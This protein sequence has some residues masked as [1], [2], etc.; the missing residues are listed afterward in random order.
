M[1]PCEEVAQQGQV[2]DQSHADDASPTVESPGYNDDS[3]SMEEDD[4]EDPEEDP[5]DEHNPRMTMRIPR[6]IPMRSMS[7]RMKILKR[8]SSLRGLMRSNHSRKTRLLS[9]HHHLDTMQRGYL[10]TYDQAPLGH[11]AAMIRMSDDIPEEDMPPR[12]RFVLTAPLPGCD[13]AESYAAAARAPRGH[14][15]FVDTVVAG[16]SLVCSPG[17]DALTIV[18]AADRA[19]DVGNATALQ[20]S[21]H[22][23][24]TSIEEVNLRI[25]Y[26]A[27]E[28]RHAYLSF[29]ARNKALLARLETLETHMS[30]MKWQRQSAE[31]LVVTQMMRIHAVEAQAWTDTVEDSDSVVGLSQWLKKMESVFHISSCA[32]D[33]QVKFATC[34]LLG[35]A[36]TWWNGR[37]RN[38]GHDAAYA[39]TWGNL[40]KKLTDKYCPKG[41]IKKLEIELWN[42]KYISGLPDNIHEHVMSARPKTLDDAIE[43]TS[44]LMDQ[45]LHTYVERQNDNKRNADDSSRNNQQPHKKQNVARAYTVSLG[46]K[47]AYTV[48]TTNN[49]NNKNQKAGACYECGDTEHIKKN[50][51]KLKNRENGVALG[52]AYAMGGRDASSDSNIITGTLLLNNRYATILFNT[53]ADRSFVSTTF[54]AL[55]DITPTTLE[56]HYDVE[57]ADRKIIRVNTIIRGCTLNFMNHPFNID[58]MPVPLGSFDVIIGMDWL[59]K[60]HGIE[61]CLTSKSIPPGIDNTNLDLDEDIRLLEELLNNDPS[62]SPLSPK[63]LNVEEIKI[64]KSSIDEPLELELK[65]L[66]SHFKYA[67]LERTDKLPVII[68]KD[69]KDNEKEAL[70]KVLKSHK[71]AIA[72]KITD[73]K[74]TMLQRCEDANLVLNWEKCH[75]MVKEGIV[76][77]YKISKNGLEVNRAKVDVIAK[78]PHPTT[79]KETPF[80]FSKDCIDALETLKK[81]RTEA[82][83]L[84]V[85]DW[86][87]PFQLMC[88]ASDFVIGAV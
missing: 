59:T 60:Y 12:R 28:V 8:R 34:T 79:V 71:R 67:Y 48:N 24:M 56:N 18:R 73:I 86:N 39:M 37:V 65:D 58:L 17:H 82:P 76:L 32:I 72:W 41:K 80:V 46:E 61:A 53:G 49:N 5:S 47:K 13:V 14:Y 23:M 84:V 2:E 10:P 77:G 51:L 43:L 3:D 63:E 16:Q 85:P 30:H 35:D 70:L 15:D 57:L 21:E 1:D 11:K 7:M 9:H 81:K 69:L 38:L 27:H 78:L 25:S 74:D 20:A 52:R 45:K 68:A 26:Q 29:E 87:L 19:E 40:K 64:V 33:N 22:R 6:R 83:I 66:P 42:L 75:F 31:D 62:L 4:D 36:L 54:S 50:C 88:D 44:D 55:I